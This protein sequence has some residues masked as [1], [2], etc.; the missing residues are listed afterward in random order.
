MMERIR[1][2]RDWIVAADPGLNQF[3]MGARA[4]ITAVISSLLLLE[5][6]RLLHRP[7]KVALIGVV[8]AIAA[9][10]LVSDPEPKQ[11]KITILLVPVV[12][13]AAATLGVVTAPIGW[14]GK[15]IFV[16]VI[17][18]AVFVRRFG[19]TYLTLGFV[20]FLSYFFSL[21]FHARFTQ[22]PWMVEA[23]G[24]ATAIGFA[25]RAWL[26]RD[27]PDR[28]LD[29]TI[30]A[31][32][33]RLRL[34]LGFLAG[35]VL[36]P[37]PGKD[38]DLRG[39]QKQ[40]AKLNRAALALESQA[41]S[42]GDWRA[43][44]FSTELAAQMLADS[45]RGIATSDADS[46]QRK[47]V[48]ELLWTLREDL[49]DSAEVAMTKTTD[50]LQALLWRPGSRDLIGELQ[51]PYRKLELAL[52]RLMATDPRGLQT[53]R[54]RP[55]GHATIAAQ[56]QNVGSTG[57]S[58]NQ[59]LTASARLA[60]QAALAGA[61]AIVAGNAISSSRWYWAVIAS[62]VVFNRA[63]TSG[64][65]ISRAWHRILGTVVGVAAG[66]FLA[67]RVNG[68]VNLE[69][70]LLFTGI[71][72][73]YYSMRAVYAGFVAVYVMLLAILYSLLGR[74]TPELMYLRLEETLL[75]AALGVAVAF[76]VFPSRSREKIR[77]AMAEVLVCMA[78]LL[79][80]AEHQPAA[81]SEVR[82]L[83]DKM[84]QLNQA[85]APVIGSSAPFGSGLAA[86]QIQD[87]STA[88]YCTRQLTHTGLRARESE[89]S[90]PIVENARA[91]AAVLQGRDGERVVRSGSDVV[92]RLYREQETSDLVQ[93]ELL[94]RLDRSLLRLAAALNIPA[95]A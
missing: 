62:F 89:A 46:S 68:H 65:T 28:I 72:A 22:V 3:R 87:I 36:R 81:I 13:S 21:Y 75:G 91:V 31:F 57:G 52:R 20:M 33:A 25:V 42:A 88:V 40:G 70:A 90:H 16:L 78:D 37:R 1:S 76:F 44:V 30:A 9:A 15:I 54:E 24:I 7:V 56:I 84:Q 80:R 64:E 8:I 41:G 95:A 61:L 49:R 71:F 38:D 55:H 58:G 59:P 77:G 45:V 18:T 60:G 26:I 48:A 6:A 39:I 4:C 73:A 83:D 11:Q 93:I 74:Y 94:D 35:V 17:F 29:E 53:M 51:L 19:T 10:A 85:T 14:L 34:W 47:A 86:R 27:R 63:S 32:H 66:L 23:I 92:N 50:R 43:A 82:D 79:E 5:I 67:D 2:S 69:L 12:A